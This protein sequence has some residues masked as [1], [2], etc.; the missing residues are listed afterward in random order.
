MV[1]RWYVVPRFMKLYSRT[2]LNDSYRSLLPANASVPAKYALLSLKCDGILELISPLYSVS[3]VHCPHRRPLPSDRHCVH[4]RRHLCFE[5][6]QIHGPEMVNS[7]RPHAYVHFDNSVAICKYQ[8]EVRI[9]E[10]HA[11]WCQFINTC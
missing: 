3:L 7:H 10:F 11:G 4:H 5:S 2:H 9:S 6:R 1:V 8:S